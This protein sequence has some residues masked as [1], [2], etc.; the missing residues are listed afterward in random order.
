MGPVL[1]FGRILIH[2]SIYDVSEMLQS[3]GSLE[4][5]LNIVMNQNSP[6]YHSSTVGKRFG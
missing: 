6:K 1:V 5:F 4:H 3:V 2:H